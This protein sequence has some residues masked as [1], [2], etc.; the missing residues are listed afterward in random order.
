MRRPA[1]RRRRLFSPLTSRGIGSSAPVRRMLKAPC[2]RLPGPRVR[3][4]ARLRGQTGRSI[5]RISR[6]MRPVGSTGQLRHRRAESQPGHPAWPL[7]SDGARVRA[8]T[9]RLHEACFH[10]RSCGHGASEG[11]R[12][13]GAILHAKRG[14]SD[15][16]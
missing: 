14:V 6:G 15:E 9:A 13:I 5:E 4:R 11:I 1:G 10:V 8:V 16:R 7:R 3:P 2:I 12:Q